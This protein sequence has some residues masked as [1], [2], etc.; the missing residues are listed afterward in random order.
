M[1]ILEC[2]EGRRSIRRFNDHPV[3]RETIEAIVKAASYSPSWKNSQTVR[4]TVITDAEMLKK[5]AEEAMAGFEKNANTLKTAKALAVQSVVKGI[6]GYNAD[7]SFTTNKNDSW[8]MYD[9][10]ISAQTFCLAAHAHGVGTVIMGIY[11]EAVCA[12]FV[13][14]PD[15]ERVT[16]LI[17][18]GYPEAPAN[19]PKRKELDEILRMI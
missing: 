8:E 18:M 2:I 13:N 7:G 10:G 6:C 9:A 12:S 11:D 19:M 3:D 15:T 4:Y 16:A 5:F 1:D 17:A 14:L